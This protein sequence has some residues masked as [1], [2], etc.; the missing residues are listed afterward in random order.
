MAVARAGQP[1]QSAQP[2]VIQWQPTRGYWEARRMWDREEKVLGSA[3]LSHSD[4]VVDPGTRKEA[5]VDRVAQ[6]KTAVVV[7][8]FCKAEG[9]C[10]YLIKPLKGKSTTIKL[11]LDPACLHETKH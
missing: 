9:T 1:V 8:N 10:W 2:E 11:A 7:G 5:S 6:A 4:V 3:L